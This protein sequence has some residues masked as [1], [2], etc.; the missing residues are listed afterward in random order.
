MAR[1]DI[2]NDALTATGNQNVAVE[3]DGSDEWTAGYSAYQRAVDYLTAV[4][5]WKF[6]TASSQLVAVSPSPSPD[7]NYSY[8]YALPTASL[9]LAGVWYL[10]TPLTD[11]VIVENQ[12]C[13]AYAGPIMAEYVVDPGIAAWPPLFTEAVRLR[14]EA[15][16]LRSLNEDYVEAEKREARAD[17]MLQTARTRGDRQQRHRSF[18]RSRIITRRQT[19]GR[20]I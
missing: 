1:I 13:C 19:G 6:A 4:H 9:S 18:Y 7:Q 11:Y 2:I 8:A 10:G 16:I 15:G 12:L 14:A 3:Y 20:P 17:E 5:D